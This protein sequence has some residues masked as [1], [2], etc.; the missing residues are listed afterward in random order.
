MMSSNIQ[1]YQTDG[2]TASLF[3]NNPKPDEAFRMSN[4]QQNQK[5]VEIYEG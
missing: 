5:E 2:H 3:A 1:K 4:P